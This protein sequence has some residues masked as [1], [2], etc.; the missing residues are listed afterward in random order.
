MNTV[1]TLY[2]LPDEWY[3]DTYICCQCETEF[4]T[5]L[6]SVPRFCP[7]AVLNLMQYGYGMKAERKQHL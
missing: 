3:Q 5:N 1:L 2:D 6:E 4:M 7:S